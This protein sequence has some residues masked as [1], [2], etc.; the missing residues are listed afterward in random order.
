MQ[1]LMSMNA[2]RGT[3]SSHV[4]TLTSILKILKANRC[5]TTLLFNVIFSQVDLWYFYEIT[6][7]SIIWVVNWCIDY[8]FY[9]QLSLLRAYLDQ[10]RWHSRDST[11]ISAPNISG[12]YHN[13]RIS[14]CIRSDSRWLRE[15]AT[16]SYRDNDRCIFFALPEVTCTVWI[17][18]SGLM[19]SCLLVW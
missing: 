5:T 4:M 7:R 8:Q 17:F 3:S 16:K 6:L 19:I 18:L 12:R 15:V 9:K 11:E 2:I 13:F 1:V 14:S 10:A